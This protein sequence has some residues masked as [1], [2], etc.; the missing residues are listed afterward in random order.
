MSSFDGAVVNQQGVEFAIAVV[1]RS[2][3]SQPAARDQAVLEFSEAFGGLPTVLMA[4]DGQGV[5]TYYGRPDIVDFL[6]SVPMEAIP[7]QRY[8]VRNS[9]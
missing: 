9:A 3:L 6:A 2:L 7:W 1:N 8:T 4:Q 5:P